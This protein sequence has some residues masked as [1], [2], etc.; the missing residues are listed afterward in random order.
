MS[1]V[2]FMAEKE[3][4]ARAGPLRRQQVTTFVGRTFT[5]TTLLDW[6]GNSLGWALNRATSIVRGQG[7]TRHGG[8]SKIAIEINIEHYYSIHLSACRLICFNLNADVQRAIR[9]FWELF[10]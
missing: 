2:L 3:N 8:Q 7:G 10:L 9:Q 4:A 1:L 6:H 5:D